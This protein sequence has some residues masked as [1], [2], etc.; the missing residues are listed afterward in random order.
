[1]ALVR[2][3]WTEECSYSADIEVDGYDPDADDRDEVLEAAICDLDGDEFRA[4]FDSVDER[5]V[6]RA[7]VVREGELTGA[8]VRDAPAHEPDWED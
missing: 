6:T 2:V 5:S 4:A 8:V 7:T 3:E 1:M